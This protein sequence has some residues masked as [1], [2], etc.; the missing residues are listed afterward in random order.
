[1]ATPYRTGIEL[2]TQDAPLDHWTIQATKTDVTILHKDDH[3]IVLVHFP[4]KNLETVVMLLT[5][6]KEQMESSQG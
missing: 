4:L 2:I 1:M 6:L 3:S 5:V